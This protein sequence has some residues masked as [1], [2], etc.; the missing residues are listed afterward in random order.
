M[1]KQ[2]RKMK[3]VLVTVRDKAKQ[4]GCDPSY[5]NRVISESKTVNSVPCKRASDGK[6]VGALSVQDWA[7]LKKEKPSLDAKPKAK[8]EVT[9]T[10][11]AKVLGVGNSQMRKLIQKHLGKIKYRKVG[12]TR[13]VI[14]VTK[15][16]LTTLQKKTGRPLPVV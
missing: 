11:A 16:E 1:A 15:K 14:C 2:K 12:R 6:T 7:K 5:L 13:V 9:L 4:F 3:I 8:N 10:E